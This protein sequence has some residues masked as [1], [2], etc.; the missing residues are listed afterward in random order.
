MSWNCNGLTQSKKNDADF[1]NLLYQHDIIFLY[2]TWTSEN[3]EIDLKGYCSFNFYRK[4]QN[5]RARR[6][7]GV[8]VVYIKSEYK[9]GVEIIKNVFDTLIWLKL[10]KTLTFRGRSEQ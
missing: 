1:I 9:Q 2:E 7:S 4:F 10:D 8:T 5:R 6:N 3:S